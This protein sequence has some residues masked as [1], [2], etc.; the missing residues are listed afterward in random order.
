MSKKIIKK[1]VD[2]IIKIRKERRLPRVEAAIAYLKDILCKI[3]AL[4]NLIA[5]INRQREA[6]SGIYYNLLS[7]DPAMESRFLAISTL[8]VKQKIKEQ[9]TQL[10]L[11]QKR[12]SRDAVQIA[13]TGYERQGKST[14]LQTITG[15]NNNI[16]PAYNGTS[17]TGAVSVIHNSDKPLVAH[18]Q[19]FKEEDFLAIV[20]DKL[21]KFFPDETFALSSLSDFEKL[22]AMMLKKAFTA[23]DATLASEFERFLDGYILHQ[24]EYLLL[25]NG[26]SIPVTNE[27]EIASYVAQYHKLDDTPDEAVRGLYQMEQTSDGKTY[28]IRYFYKH[29]AVKS[30]DI[31][32]SFP[33]I[34]DA[35]IILV[36]TIGLGDSTDALRIEEE[37]FRILR[38]DCDAAINIFCP[39]ALGGSFNSAQAA[40]ITKVGKELGSREPNRWFYYVLNTVH[41]TVGF[42]ADL[43]KKIKEQTT[44][45]FQHIK[46]APVADILEVDLS[47]AQEVYTQLLTPILDGI[48][49]HLTDIDNKL[50]ENAN[51]EGLKLYQEYY[52]LAQNI[53]KVVTNTIQQGSEEMIIFDRL[54]GQLT[55][56]A[57]L[58]KLDKQYAAYKNSP[59]REVKLNL[60]M[61]IENI[62]DLIPDIDDIA[63]EV[64]RSGHY[65]MET[66]YHFLDVLRNSIFEAFEH[67][68]TDVLHPLQDKVKLDVVTI[69]FNA[70]RLG[71]I[72][73][74]GYEIEQGPSLE[75]LNTFIDE[76]VDCQQFPHLHEA[77][78][79]IADYRINIEGLVEYRVAQ[80]I[81]T[82]DPNS[83]EHCQPN[84]Q[85]AAEDAETA[86][87]IWDAIVSRT[88]PTQI[89]M[90][91]W[92]N[93][94]ALIPSHSFYARVY[95][96]CQKI[97]RDNQTREELRN[98]YVVNRTTIWR[99]LFINIEAE[100][101]ALGDWNTH[102]IE[103]IDMCKRDCFMIHINE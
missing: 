31:Y 3:T 63:E 45:T 13:I 52:H 11:L 98:F 59:C 47:N 16:I 77:L 94:Y 5:K 23:T 74:V 60:D 48:T 24:N 90:R 69:L 82:L 92:S 81:G 91:Q 28:W 95:K 76:R 2:D 88:S 51:S 38:E 34:D 65:L 99:D 17:C 71:R 40:I 25:I 89:K 84:L 22:D 103:L 97:V 79:F 29:L 43:V 68:N 66:Y 32:T 39:G 58:L 101:T 19:F 54:F 44:N 18:I 21:K 86:E 10:E 70:A 93:E 1:K 67:I 4:D 36:D 9:L 64:A 83:N 50:I 20:K 62:Y 102:S 53:A 55:Y 30:V 57:D 27:E 26:D 56:V 7:Q 35:K 75:W 85:H 78:R 41:S 8:S 73:L 96:F 15:L 72:P 87:R 37:M 80:S 42:N 12:F 100:Q 33:A 46:P 14:C 6:K 49:E 61:V